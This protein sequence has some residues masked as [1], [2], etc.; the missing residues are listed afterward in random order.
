MLMALIDK[1]AELFIS[2]Y[3]G[4]AVR[5]ALSAL[6]GVLVVTVGLDQ[7]LVNQWVLSTEPIAIGVSVYLLA[8]LMSFKE[9]RRRKD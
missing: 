7:E 4:S 3:L 8:L 9:K 2:K 6:A 1:I 5:H